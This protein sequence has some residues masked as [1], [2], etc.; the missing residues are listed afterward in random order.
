[1][2]FGWVYGDRV[3][4]VVRKESMPH[5]RL[6]GLARRLVLGAMESG[7]PVFAWNKGFEEQFLGVEGL[8]E[9]QL[10]EYEKKDAS[11]SWGVPV[12]TEGSMVPLLWR[13]GKREVVLMRAVYDALIEAAS[14]PRLILNGVTIKW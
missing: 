14:L 2:A 8:H 1:M 12:P 9:L 11:L 10:R 3:Y 7:V 13:Q 6:R 4:G 5:R